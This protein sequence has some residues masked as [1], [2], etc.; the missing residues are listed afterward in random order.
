METRSTGRV[1]PYVPIAAEE[2]AGRM[3]IFVD[4]F[5]QLTGPILGTSRA[6]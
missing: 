5:S 4:K 6:N 2:L 3:P 1:N